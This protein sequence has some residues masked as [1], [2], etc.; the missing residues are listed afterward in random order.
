MEEHPAPECPKITAGM[1]KL[2]SGTAS[3]VEKS[4]IKS[5]ARQGGY[6]LVDERLRVHRECPARSRYDARRAGRSGGGPGLEAKSRQQGLMRQPKRVTPQDP[7]PR[8]GRTGH[9][10]AVG[11]RPATGA[12]RFDRRESGVRGDQ[13]PRSQGSPRRPSTL[14]GAGRESGESEAAPGKEPPQSQE[15]TAVPS[16]T[17]GSPPRTFL[18]RKTPRPDAERI[19]PSNGAGPAEEARVGALQALRPPVPSTAT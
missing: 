3:R 6:L 10:S 15:S 5:G 7:G 13:S 12:P 2:V 19:V 1:R 9:V 17:S 4:D 18:S 14:A 11:P 8:D 16:E